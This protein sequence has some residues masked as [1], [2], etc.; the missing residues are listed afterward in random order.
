M[1]EAITVLAALA[2]IFI[3]VCRLDLVHGGTQGV[4]M[5]LAY[6]PLAGGAAWG[7]RDV[8]LAQPIPIEQVVALVIVA[9]HLLLASEVVRQRGR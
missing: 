3:V 5:Y 9:V 8:L 7:L 2:I 6:A 4:L 1:V